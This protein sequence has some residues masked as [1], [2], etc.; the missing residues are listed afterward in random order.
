MKDWYNAKQPHE[1][2]IIMVLG[3]IVALALIYLIIWSP[4]SEAYSQKMKRVE[5]QRTLLAWMQD[6][7]QKINQ[8]Q[9]TGQRGQTSGAPLLSTVDNTIKASGLGQSMKRLEPQGNHKV[10]IWFESTDF[11]QLIS[12][13]AK[14][15]SD[16]RIQVNSINIEKQQQ[17]GLVNARLIL[18][19]GL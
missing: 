17:P 10:Q 9:N 19:K 16:H 6:T 12:S 7:G 13:L 18:I 1:Q 8:L 5:A 2:R 3:I 11:N 15:D 4:A 14:L